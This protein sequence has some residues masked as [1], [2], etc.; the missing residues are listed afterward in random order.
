MNA[1]IITIGD[2]ILIGQVLNTNAAYIGEKL[3]RHQITINGSSIVGDI[4]KKIIA[5]F[6]KAFIDNDVVLVTGGLGPTHD[7]ITLKC[8]AEFFK[9]ELVIDS[10]V[11]SDVKN[12][13]EQRGRILTETNEKQALVPKIATPIRNSKGTAPGVWI[14]KDGKIFA[15][16]PGVPYEMKEMMTSFIL[17]KLDK[18]VDSN[19]VFVIKNLLATGIPESNL[20]DK[21]ENIEELLQGAKMA[22]LPN[23]FGV[24]LRITTEGST[25]NDAQNKIDE[26]EQKIRSKAGKFIYGTENDTLESVVANLLL[27][28]GLK[29][30]T[31]ESCTGGQI[32]HRLTNISG[33]S[34]YFE[35]GITAY[36]NA[37]KVELLQVDED[38]IHK[39]GAVSKEVAEQMARGI[40]SISGTDIGLS[41]TGI[42]GPGGATPTK[43]VGYVI[44]A[45]CDE[46]SCI[47][48][49]FRFGDDRL[50]NKDRT[51]QAALEMV[52]RN[53]LGIPYED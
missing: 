1:H 24:R 8:I 7:D 27:E 33:S 35:R 28:R 5:E 15:A 18:L 9:T 45:L 19:K 10:N 40:K 30:S 31:A 21:L 11:L 29:I 48:K 38:A 2:E 50:L 34:V 17:P 25:Q 23:Q 36:S 37:A 6:K 51:S 52:R 20:Y 44:I 53:L 47:S 49:E 14:E 42:L 3:T 26:I 13:F 32:S 4:D 16:M 12:F 39:Y 41:V 46:K 43:P 22:F